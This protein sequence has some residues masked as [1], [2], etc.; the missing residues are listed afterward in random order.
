MYA[1]FET[2]S[3]KSALLLAVST[4]IIYLIVSW[5][6]KKTPDKLPPGPREWNTNWEILKAT[7]T[8]SFVELTY[9]WAK[10]YGPLTFVYSLGQPLLLINCPET[11]RKLFAADEYK[12]LLADRYTNEASRL[13][14]YNGK[15]LI[16]SKYDDVMRKKRKLFHST[17]RLYGDGVQKFE[18]VALEEMQRM[19]AEIDAAGGADFDLSATLSRSLKIIIYILALGE[20]PSDP[21]IPDI[22]EEY[23]IAFNK[24]WAPDMDFVISNIRILTKVPGKYKT[25]VDRLLKAK[26]A[27]E[28]LMYF[29]PKKT[30][31]PGQPRGIADLWFDQAN[32]PGNE[33]MRHDPEHVIA[34]LTSIFF[35]AHLTSRS[36]L[37]GVFLCMMNYPNI[38]KKIQEEV[39][40]V[41]GSRS[42]RLD[43]RRDMP[44][45]EATILESLRL[46]SQSPL[47]GVRTASEDIHFQGMVIPK[48]TLVY[49][50]TGY[51]FR[52]EKYYDDPWTFKP[53]RFLDSQGQ[54]LPVDHPARRNLIPF[55]VGVRT[56]PGESFARSR[57]FLFLTSILQR[58]DILPPA[59]EKMVP[60]DF[61]V[62]DEAVA[63]FVRQCVRYKCRLIRREARKD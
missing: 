3:V 24:L 40:T 19:F 35:A 61:T 21:A 26:R 6:F 46:I 45:T 9:E 48:N 32:L 56:C 17:L 15:D 30:H 54:L 34:V 28:E 38:A 33:W 16:F 10:K 18:N 62:K 60:A 41:V 14:W 58:Y 13:A 49:I 12:L 7:W 36:L 23:D 25:A 53:E 27:A 55:G 20:R 1:V 43:N 37:L 51:I 59:H 31:I 42:P 8:D 63:G 29:N 47:S 22:L 52:S 11:G 5:L 57:G 44:Y 2:F 50:N 4:L 39:D